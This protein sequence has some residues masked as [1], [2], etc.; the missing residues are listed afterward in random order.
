[1]TEERTLKLLVG[2]EMTSLKKYTDFNSLFSQFRYYFQKPAIILLHLCQIQYWT[3]NLKESQRN[4]IGQFDSKS[5]LDELMREVFSD[6]VDTEC[7]LVWILVVK[8]GLSA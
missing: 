4:I 3:P 8:T 6:C 7:I 5:H 2:L 1:M